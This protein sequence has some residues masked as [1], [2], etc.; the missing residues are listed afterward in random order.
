MWFPNTDQK[1]LNTKVTLKSAK[2]WDTGPYIP[3][4]DY[5]YLEGTYCFH[6]QGRSV[7]QENYQKNRKQ[8]SESLLVAYLV[9]FST[10]MM[11]AVGFCVNF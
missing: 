5:S 2:F 1:L 7:S 11:E 10:L 6:F 3:I 4:D 9:Y 8:Y